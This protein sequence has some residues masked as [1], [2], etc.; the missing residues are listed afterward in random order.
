MDMALHIIRRLF[1]EKKAES[2]AQ[3]AEYIWNKD[4]AN[5]PFA[6]AEK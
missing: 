5:D 1:N 6:L 3:L 2:V 4:A